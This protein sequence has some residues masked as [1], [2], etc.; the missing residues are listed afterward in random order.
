[1]P[2][3]SYVPLQ[4]NGSNPTTFT[5][6]IGENRQEN[7]FPRFQLLTEPTYQSNTVTGIP[8]YT[9]ATVGPNEV[10]TKL[11]EEKGDPRPDLQLERIRDILRQDIKAL[12]NER[13]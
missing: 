10:T 9:S 12:D 1:M 13:R 2:Q 11:A 3:Q 4:Q 8:S 7:Q 5:T 6:L